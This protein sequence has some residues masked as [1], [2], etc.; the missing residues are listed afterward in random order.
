MVTLARRRKV[1]PKE[2]FTVSIESLDEEGRG[3]AKVNGKTVYVSG[4]IAGEVVE[5]LYTRLFNRYDEARVVKILH[6]SPDRVEPQCEHVSFCGGCSLQHI[7]LNA[8]LANKQAWLLTQLKPFTHITSDNILKPI[9]SVGYHYRRKARLGVRYVHKKEKILVG[10]RERS[11]RYLADLNACPILMPPVNNLI[12][13]LSDLISS[14]TCSDAIPQIEVAI[15]DNATALVFRHITHLDESDHQKI[16]AFA[17]MRKIHA[18]LQPSGLYSVHRI[19][20]SPTGDL[21]DELLS[22]QL[23]TQNL[24][25][26]FHPCDFIQINAKVNQK[27]I[28]QVLALLELTAD[29]NVLDLFSGLGNFS[30]PIAQQARSVH[31]VEGVDVMVKRARYNAKCNNIT[32][33]T[34]IHADLEQSLE[35]YDWFTH[36][37]NKVV[38]DPPRSGAAAIIPSL[39]N[40]RPSHIVYVSCN[41]TTLVTDAQQ[42]IENG[43]RLA[44]IGIVDMF[45]QTAHIESIAQFV[46]DN[47][48]I[49]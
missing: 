8:Q 41:P 10:F 2:S 4:A 44:K 12:L 17:K 43:Y 26:H 32:N 11:G 48:A 46:L 39:I 14:L 15:G 24:T 40:K 34:S 36:D 3:I 38:I 9:T 18:Y 28:N 19:Y 27:L 33:I 13:P 49:H 42:L 30:L 35:S 6:T 20:P 23:P 31:T 22:Y 5:C 47:Q 21:Q 1:L 7:S 45:S 16:I 37:Y 29:D 25:L